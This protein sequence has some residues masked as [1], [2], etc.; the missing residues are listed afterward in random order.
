MSCKRKLTEL[1]TVNEEKALSEKSVPKSSRYVTKLSF[2]RL[3][4]PLVPHP[5]GTETK[6]ATRLF[7]M[8][9]SYQ[10]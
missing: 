1:K 5:P 10:V 2:N 8:S 9:I 6:A 4:A 7:K 3:F